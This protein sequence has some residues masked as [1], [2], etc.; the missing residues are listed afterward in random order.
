MKWRLVIKGFY[1]KL[2]KTETIE[3]KSS[4]VVQPIDSLTTSNEASVD[5][6]EHDEIDDEDKAIND[7]IEK[8]LETERKIEKKWGFC[9]LI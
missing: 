3:Q 8:N 7:E 5:E 2:L 4:S 6:S 1:E 9:F